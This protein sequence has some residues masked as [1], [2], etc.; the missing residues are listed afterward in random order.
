MN[1]RQILE[2]RH[3]TAE[4]TDLIKKRS[5]QQEDYDALKKELADN[6]EIGVLLT[7]TGGVRKVRLKSSSR[8]K[9]GGFRVCYYYYTEGNAIYLLY[10]FQKNEQENL[11]PE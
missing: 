1:K 5:L 6:P 9:S 8:G 4:V 11:T 2:T 3:F 7:G 10:V